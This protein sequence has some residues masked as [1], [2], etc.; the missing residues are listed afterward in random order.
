MSQFTLVIANKAYSSWSLRPW[1][2]LKQAGIPF[3]EKRIPLFR[4]ESEAALR[5]FTPAGKVPVLLDGPLT[6]WDSL[7]ICEYLAETFPEKHLWPRDRTA[8]AVARSVSA[9][10]HSGFGDLRQN[11]TMNVRKSFPGHGRTPAVLQD[12]ERI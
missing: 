5:E 1:L 11:M 2:V 3:T 4:S 8:R 12:I 9:E 6:I 7:A 10:M